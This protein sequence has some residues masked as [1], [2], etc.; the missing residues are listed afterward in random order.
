MLV[1]L[2]RTKLLRAEVTAAMQ[3]TSEP[4]RAEALVDA[5]VSEGLAGESDG[6][7]SLP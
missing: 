6:L 4:A 3:L 5:L 7:V 1:H 2:L